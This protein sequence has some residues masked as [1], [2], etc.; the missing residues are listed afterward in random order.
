MRSAFKMFCFEG[1]TGIYVML[2]R[3]AKFK[4]IGRFAVFTVEVKL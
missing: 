3:G 1:A 4:V 2:I